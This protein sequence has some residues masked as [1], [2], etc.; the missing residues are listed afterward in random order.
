MIKMQYLADEMQ[1]NR[2]EISSYNTTPKKFL[3]NN[4]APP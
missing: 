2:Y 3:K 4:N 1:K